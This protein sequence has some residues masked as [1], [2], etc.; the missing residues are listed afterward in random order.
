MVGFCKHGDESLGFIKSGEMF[1]R[2]TI[3]FSRKVF[4]IDLLILNCAVRLHRG[5]F[6]IT[7]KPKRMFSFLCKPQS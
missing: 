7:F 1:D 2:E 5:Y 3:S 6:L 4:Y